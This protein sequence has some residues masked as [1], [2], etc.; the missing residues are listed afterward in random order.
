MHATTTTPC[1]VRLPPNASPADHLR[2]RVDVR[3]HA[4]AT[5]TTQ[6]LGCRTAGVAM[7]YKLL[8][9]AQDRWRRVNGHELVA[10]VRAGAT[11]IDGQ[12]QERTPRHPRP[13]R[14]LRF[15]K[16]LIHNY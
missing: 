7:A 2:D 11:F 15:S 14:R 16:K 6:G 3:D 4:A 9:A 13:A 5:A 12:P 1:H 8:D 10:L